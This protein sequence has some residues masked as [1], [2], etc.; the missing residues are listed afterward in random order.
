MGIS[1]CLVQMDAIPWFITVRYTTLLPCEVSWKRK[2]KF[3][4]DH[5]DTEVLLKLLTVHGVEALPKLNGMFAFA[6]YDMKHRT[7]L[8]ARDR[9]GIK[10]FYYSQCFGNLV[11]ASEL[12]SLLLYPGLGREP[13]Y[14]SL[15][16]YFSLQYV[17]GGRSSMANVEQ[18][19]P[20]SYLTYHLDSK[21]LEIRRW[22]SPEFTG[23]LCLKR[24]ELTEYLRELIGEAVDRWSVADV[25][26]GCLLSGG[27]IH[28]QLLACLRGMVMN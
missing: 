7:L 27:W 5:S 8:C 1:L 26:V 3:K 9:F 19:A 10:P 11:F 24:D 17:V 13:D 15:F 12:K 14:Q 28:R 22:W 6:F 23:E 25:P 21:H 4:S 20:G 18:L 16:H 2:D